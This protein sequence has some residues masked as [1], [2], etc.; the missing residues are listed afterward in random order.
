MYYSSSRST[1][2]R[3]ARCLRAFLET[4]VALVMVRGDARGTA[5]VRLVQDFGC[6]DDPPDMLAAAPPPA[7]HGQPTPPK[8][9]RGRPPGKNKNPGS[10]D[11]CERGNF[12]NFR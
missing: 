7:P 9:G 10:A 12:R 4:R 1:R 11:G 2:R 3:A 5:S 6:P 8:R